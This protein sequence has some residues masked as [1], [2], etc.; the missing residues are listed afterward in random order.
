MS[1][2]LRC[3]ERLLRY[4][5]VI[6]GPSSLSDLAYSAAPFL[7]RLAGRG[8]NLSPLSSNGTTILLER[9]QISPYGRCLSRPSSCCRSRA[10]S[11]RLLVRG[12]LVNE[13]GEVVRRYLRSFTCIWFNLNEAGVG[14]RALRKHRGAFVSS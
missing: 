6:G 13:F 11:D 12:L 8:R 2:G 14:G 1:L 4:A 10:K 3:R 9:E 7:L 5:G